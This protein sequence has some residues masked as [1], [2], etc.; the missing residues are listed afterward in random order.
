MSVV[1]CVTPRSNPPPCLWLGCRVGFQP[2][3][4]PQEQIKKIRQPEMVCA[5]PF[6]VARRLRTP[7]VARLAMTV[8]AAL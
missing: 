5:M 2:T 1:E 8:G 3:I 4:A 7:C 6:S